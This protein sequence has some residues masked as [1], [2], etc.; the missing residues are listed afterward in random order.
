MKIYEIISERKIE[1][2]SLLGGAAKWLLTHWSAKNFIELLSKNE[3]LMA[4]FANGTPPSIAEIERLYGRK[5]ADLMR[6]DDTIL[7]KAAAKRAETVK[8]AAKDAQAGRDAHEIN[9]AKVARGGSETSA[10]PIVSNI[11]SNSASRLGSKFGKLPAIASGLKNFLLAYEFYSYVKDYRDTVAYW[12]DQLAKGNI[13]P[14]DYA[15]YRQRAMSHLMTQIAG[16][17]IGN[18]SILTVGGFLKSW[19]IFGWMN[20]IRT[21]IGGLSGAGQV[22]FMSWLGSDQGRAYLAELL[23]YN[24]IDPWW[25]GAG[26]TGL[27]MLQGKIKEIK[28][29]DKRNSDDDEGEGETS[30]GRDTSTQGKPA[31]KRDADEIEPAGKADGKEDSLGDLLG[32]SLSGPGPASPGGLRDRAIY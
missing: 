10:N 15:Q 4:R 26:I 12:E 6:A 24:E 31:K 25:G 20:P 9:L 32:K 27:E 30:S 29:K 2:A 11:V 7:S 16:A 8:A 21:L 5:A 18:A 19:C 23:C 1:E 28:Q 3:N 13:T 22:M 17:L 14:N